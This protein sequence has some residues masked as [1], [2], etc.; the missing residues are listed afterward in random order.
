MLAQGYTLI[1]PTRRLSRYLHHHHAAL[2]IK[3]GK[4]CWETPDILPWDSWL[5]RSFDQDIGNHLPDRVLLT[6]QQQQLVWQD[7]IAHSAHGAKIFQK[8]ITA[9]QAIRSWNVCRQWQMPIF[10]ENYYLNEDAFAFQRWA[11]NWQQSCEKNAWLDDAV[12]PDVL[13]ASASVF[14]NKKIFLFGFDQFTPQQRALL[15]ALSA[16]G[17]DVQTQSLQRRGHQVFAYG[18]TDSHEE[19]TA[20]AGWARSLLET[21][22]TDTRIGIVI[23]NLNALHETIEN[24]MD[25]VFNPAAIR[26]DSPAAS[27]PYSIS[28]GQPLQ[29]YPLIDTALQTV[30]LAQQPLLL[31]EFG[32]M[33]RSPFIKGHNAEQQQRARLDALLHKQGEYRM[34]FNSLRRLLESK[35][36]KDDKLPVV[37][38]NILHELEK[39]LQTLPKKQ[40]AS[41]WAQQFTV[42]LKLCGWPG[43]RTLNSAEYQTVAEWQAIMDQLAGLDRVSSAISYREALGQLRQIVSNSHFQPETL[44]TPVQVLGMTGVAGMQFDH[45][46]IMGLHAGQWPP[47]PDPDPFIPIKLQRDCGLPQSSPALMLEQSEQLTASLIDSSPDVILS[48]PRQDRDQILR[49]SP[50]IKKQLADLAL[51]PP[52]NVSSYAKLLYDSRQQETIHDSQAPVISPGEKVSGGTSLFR[53]QAACPFRAF[54]RHRLFAETLAT[55]DIGLDGMER[56]SLMHEIMEKFWKKIP[57]Q[58]TLL[59]K[60]QNEIAEIIEQIVHYTLVDYQKRFPHTFTERFVRLEAERLHIIMQQALELECQ[61]QPFRVK[62]CEYWHS[63]TLNDITMRSRID[64]IDQLLDG[65]YVIIDYKTGD[66]KVTSWLSDRPDEPQLPLYAITSDGDIAAIVFTR[67]RR[68]EVAFAG[69]A[70]QQDL[71]PGVNTVSDTRGVKDKVPD[72]QSLINEWRRVLSALATRFREGDAVVGPKNSTTCNHCDLHTLCRIYEKESGVRSQEPGARI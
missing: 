68:G 44:E 66:A 59:D 62:A 9:R 30:A 72:W 10:P 69:L 2:Q 57:D 61:R 63:F 19:I 5:R 55:R 56:G 49:P 54:A 58:K 11:G 43:E 52:V 39:L 12:L 29:N 28:R 8:A 17:C 36:S 21:T 47:K 7:I 33:L 38:L 35:K 31:D 3:S 32:Q 13:A 34:S 16:S 26:V 14:R 41:F 18:Y 40:S 45:L 65:R 24:I 50:L 71:L 22:H 70:E 6:A 42:M 53:D 15:G 4:T 25:D 27:R 64:R 23:P 48:F 37:F 51:R 20:A 46:W 67:L 1:T 60:P